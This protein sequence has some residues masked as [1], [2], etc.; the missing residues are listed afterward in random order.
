[1]NSLSHFS[2]LAVFWFSFVI[3]LISNPN[4]K[5]RLCN[6]FTDGTAALAIW[7]VATLDAVLEKCSWNRTANFWL[8]EMEKYAK[9]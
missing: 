8:H 3:Q 7:P 6:N 2:H 4:K 1:M 9:Q 5:Y